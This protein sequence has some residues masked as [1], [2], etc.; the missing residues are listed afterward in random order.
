MKPI[1]SI[2]TLI[3]LAM[4]VGCS[5]GNG[6]DLSPE[7]SRKTISNVPDWFVN[8]PEKEGYKY[9]SATATSQDLQMAI[10]KAAL[11]AANALTGQMD[12][13]MSALVKRAQEET[14]LGSNSQ[15][16]DQ[17]TQ[18][19]EQIISQSLKDYRI[20]K[21]ELQEEKGNIYRAYVLIEWDADAAQKR[22]LAQ[23]KADEQLYTAMRATELFDEMEKKVEAYR[24]RNK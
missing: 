23:I 17:F 5:S 6:P 13:E 9:H 3:I 11:N 12:S 15:V 16:I 19:Q 1:I 7:A 18:T 14:G 8:T 21:K 2:V 20:A 24:N 22:L 10:D 4:F